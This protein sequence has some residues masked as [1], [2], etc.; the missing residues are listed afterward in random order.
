MDIKKRF[1]SLTQRAAL[2]SGLLICC[3]ASGSE[4]SL[5]KQCDGTIYIKPEADMISQFA[6]LELQKHLQ[7]VL[8]YELPIVKTQ[9]KAGLRFL[10]GVKPDGD[11]EPYDIEEGRYVIEPN[12]VYLYG[13]DAVLWRT[14]KLED[15]FTMSNGIRY[16]R[17]GTL[18]ATYF[19][20]EEELGI[21]WLEPGDQGIAYTTRK[22]LQLRPQRQNWHSHFPYLRQLRSGTWRSAANPVASSTLR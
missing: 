15:H 22:K 18:F 14:T 11:T 2:L 17:M 10:V 4:P 19:F 13:D 7:L 9:Q 5:K 8:G 1:R 3:V 21:R 20:L 16:N 12:R 6:A